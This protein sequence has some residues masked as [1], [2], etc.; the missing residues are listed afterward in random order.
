MGWQSA[1]AIKLNFR[2]QRPPHTLV[3][4]RS[5]M[6]WFD[7]I[8]GWKT[9]PKQPPPR[10]TDTSKPGYFSESALVELL[11]REYAVETWN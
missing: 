2:N 11:H 3:Y 10:G 8:G 6:R 4:S 9:F 5:T 7:P 1:E